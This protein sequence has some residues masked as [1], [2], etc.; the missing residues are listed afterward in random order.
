MLSLILVLFTNVSFSAVDSGV[1]ELGNMEALQSL[2]QTKSINEIDDLGYPLLSECYRMNRPLMAE[3][4]VKAGAL[5]DQKDIEGKTALHHAVQLGKVSN[6]RYLLQN[7]A[8][9]NLADATHLTPLH[10]AA[11]LG[12][13]EM[14]R[15]LIEYK[16]D[17]FAKSTGHSVFESAIIADQIRIVKWYIQ[18]KPELLH[19][20]DHQGLDMVALALAAGNYDLANELRKM[21]ASSEI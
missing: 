1:I 6:V 8:S 5:L 16:V 18:K 3:M 12:H 20:R 7:G 21:G 4:L 13:L 17:A 10:L 9:P 11:Q 2:I 19:S 15:L 14:F